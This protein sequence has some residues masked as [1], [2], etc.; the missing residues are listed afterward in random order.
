M[1]TLSEPKI[2]TP[3]NDVLNLKD[4]Y[5]GLELN[6]SNIEKL[7]SNQVEPVLLKEL[8]KE[9]LLN[10]ESSSNKDSN[11]I[12][13][14]LSKIEKKKTIEELS[15]FGLKESYQ[16][17]NLNIIIRYWL[18]LNYEKYKDFF[19]T[20]S[21]ITIFDKTFNNILIELNNDNN[22]I[23]NTLNINRN[24]YSEQFVKD[25]LL[26]INKYT[27]IFT[28]EEE[29]DYIEIYFLQK[30]TNNIIDDSS[31]SI[32][33]NNNKIK[34]YQYFHSY[35]INDCNSF[36]IKLDEANL[37]N[38]LYFIYYRLLKFIQIPDNIVYKNEEIIKEL[39]NKSK[40]LLKY[41]NDTLSLSRS[42]SSVS[43]GSIDEEFMLK[44][45]QKTL[46][47]LFN[48]KTD[49]I[50]NNFKLDKFLDYPHHRINT[51]SCIDENIKQNLIILLN[52]L[53]KMYVITA[54]I[55]NNI[56][57]KQIDL[58]DGDIVLETISKLDNSVYNLL[59]KNKNEFISNSEQQLIN[60]KSK[61]LQIKQ[62]YN[63]D[64]KKESNQILKEIIIKKYNID[65]IKYKIVESIY[66]I[67]NNALFEGNLVNDTTIYEEI[68]FN[69]NSTLEEYYS[70]IIIDDNLDIYDYESIIFH[71][72]SLNSDIF[73]LLSKLIID[74]KID[75]LQKQFEEEQKEEQ[76]K[77][78]R[79]QEELK[80]KE[81]EQRKQ[82]EE[83]Q[84]KQEEEQRKQ[85]EEQRKQ[86]EEQ[87]KQ[88]EEQ[89]KQQEEQRKQ[90]EE[91]RK[92]QE[93]KEEQ[94]KQ[95]EELKEKEEEQKQEEQLQ[96][97]QNESIEEFI[98]KDELNGLDIKWYNSNKDK[99][100]FKKL[101]FEIEEIIKDKQQVYDI[102]KLTIEFKLLTQLSNQIK[103]FKICLK[104]SLKTRNRKDFDALK[105]KLLNFN[106][107][108][109]DKYLEKLLSI[110]K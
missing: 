24:N 56:L 104:K 68:I 16:F 44:L 97:K 58:K 37:D 40:Y 17:H 96:E 100:E 46:E 107:K 110:I 54:I 47:S 25:N 36:T 92:Q 77:E 87:R 61:I 22:L 103:T 60:I 39:N 29:Y 41:K 33:I 26:I 62:N 18:Y 20:E 66:Q 27:Y 19:E 105:K 90:E 84:R 5:L 72:Q 69:N 78:Q 28:I 43:S 4:K 21:D 94:R 74:K 91:Q 80:E 101:Q 99:S 89:R 82:Q 2:L 64:L 14:H 48:K 11:I 45:Q 42:S 73:T 31:L 95:Q 63:E 83:E 55:L 70:K 6:I 3:I 7:L 9:K 35:S 52:S 75:T 38:S 85:Q 109:W 98:N 79:K 32:N 106:S 65:I 8:S 81:E 13:E 88:E 53:I 108:D 102:L 1:S 71:H 12:F 93:L 30:I 59:I 10:T 15:K 76:K 86:Q 49:Y 67:K 50:T 23:E 51:M 57:L 34:Y